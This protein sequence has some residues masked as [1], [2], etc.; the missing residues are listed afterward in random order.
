MYCNIRTFLWVSATI[1]TVVFEKGITEAICSLRDCQHFIVDITCIPAC[2]SPALRSL[3]KTV[4]TVTLTVERYLEDALSVIAESCPNL[5]KLVLSL[6][7]W[8]E[9]RA[10]CR[11]PPTMTILELRSDQLQARDKYYKYLIVGLR[12]MT[13]EG[14]RTVQ[15]VDSRNCNDMRQ[16]SSIMCLARAQLMGKWSILDNKGRPFLDETN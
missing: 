2:W 15:L 11:F 12:S 7:R 4:M 9:F 13:A 10:G 6:P 16:H 5:R 1:T 8:A 3:G 14:L